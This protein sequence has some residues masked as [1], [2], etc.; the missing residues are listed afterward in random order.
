MPDPKDPEKINITPSLEEITAAYGEIVKHNERYTGVGVA[1]DSTVNNLIVD[2][3]L[4]DEDQLELG[5]PRN[6]EQLPSVDRGDRDAEIQDLLHRNTFFR[7][8]VKILPV[9]DE[10]MYDFN[11][12][13]AAS[14]ELEPVVVNS[15]LY[16]DFLRQQTKEGV[17]RDE[18]NF[19][20][21]VSVIR[22][23]RKIIE[24]FYAEGTPK[25]LDTELS[26]QSG[27]DALRTFVAID[28]QYQRLGLD[29]PEI[30]SKYLDAL[31]SGYLDEA[32]KKKRL[33]LDY[34]KAYQELHSYVHYWGENVLAEYIKIGSPSELSRPK[35]WLGYGGTDLFEE[36]VDYIAGLIGPQRTTEFGLSSAKA[37]ISGI[38]ETLKM[39]S[40]KPDY[41]LNS[42]E[43]VREVLERNA[44]RLRIL[45]G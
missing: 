5:L 34:Q 32:L 23:L 14:T 18:A 15:Q 29:M 1:F 45:L 26:M 38:E 4:Q 20:L 40:D 13:K 3:I 22:T 12:S 25:L 37:M 35:D 19:G 31:D 16:L 36:Q 8:G 7:I 21:M 2:A 39:M 30:Y 28:S 9:G 41:W 44:K 24:T 11:G 43:G 17:N 10:T 33:A 6:N 27:E 42:A